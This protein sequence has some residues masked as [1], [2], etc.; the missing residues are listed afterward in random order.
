M[1]AIVAG[2]AAAHAASPGKAARSARPPQGTSSRAAREDA[3]RSIPYAQLD[4]A[5]RNKISPVLANPTIFRCL[6]A[7][8]IECDSN[9][10][11]FLVEHPD[12]VVNLWEVMGISEVALSRVAEATFDA[13]DKAG[14]RGRLEYV[15]HGPELHVVFA[16]GDYTGSMLPR[17]VR[18]QCVLL[19]RTS[20]LRSSDGRDF[21]RCKLDAF[22]RL[23]NVGVG[24]LAKTFQPLVLNSADHNFRETVS[25]LGSVHRAAEFNHAGVQRLAERLENVDAAQR[26]QFA[27]LTTRVAVRAALARSRGPSQAALGHGT[28]PHAARTATRPAGTGS[29]R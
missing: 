18:G 2:A 26:E 12:L 22:L 5:A 27:D 11:L 21:V 25:F 13:N 29:Q 19:L 8:T 3:V 6:P 9:L 28:R 24:V 17:P 23:D 15:Y 10:Y 4:R 20:Y 7:Q 14:T 16:E 1:I